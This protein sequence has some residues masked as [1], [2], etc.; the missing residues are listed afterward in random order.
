MV[1][2]PALELDGQNWKIYRA[3][4][5]EHAATYYCLDVLA[6]RPDD[7]T[8]D[9]HGSNALLWCTF[10]ETAPPTIYV[11]IR[12]KT[13]HE[14][15]NYLANCFRDYDP[16]QE[17][18][19]K[20]F[21]ARAN[22]VKHDPSAENPTS[23]Y[24]AI[25][26][27]R[28]NPPTKDLTRGT[29]DVDNRNVGR[30]QDPC[31]SPEAS[32]E[33]N[34]AECANGTSVLLTGEP[35]E[36]QNVPQDSLPLT[37]RPP[38]D[39]KPGECKQEAADGVVTAGCTKGAV[40]LAKPRKSDA[41]VDGKAAL[42]RVL[43]ER[44]HIVSEGDETERDGQSRLQQAEFYCKERCQ[45]NENANA[46][47]PST[48]ELPLEGEWTVCASGEARDPRGSANVPNATPECVHRPNESRETEDAEGVESEGCKGGTSGR[49][50]VDETVECCQQLCMADGDGGREV[51]PADTPNESETL[52]TVSIES[53]SPDGGGIPRVHLGSMSWRAGDANGPGNQA[54]GQ[55][56]GSRGWT[57]TLKVSNNA[58]TDGMS[59]GEGAETYLGAGGAKRV[60]NA[61]DGVGSR[62]DASTGPTDVPRVRTDAITTANASD[63]VSIPREESNMPNSPMET[64]KRT[65]DV[66]D[67]CGSHTDVSSAR[68]DA[69]C[70]GNDTETAT[71][72]TEIVRSHQ[73]KRKSQDSPNGH[74]IATP[75]LPGRW[76]KVS[77]GGGDVYVPLNTPIAV[78]TRQ[79][80]F[81]RVESGVEAIAPIA[82]SERA[83]DGDG[84]RNGGDGDGDDAES[85]GNVNSQR[86]EGARLST[87]SQRVCLHQKSQE[88]SPASSRPS[89]QPES[90][91]YGLVRRRRRCGRLKIER[92]NFNQVS[93]TPEDE[94]TH[95]E[96]VCATQLPRNGPNQAYGVYRPRRQRGR[97]KS[98]PTN[99]SRTRNS[100][101]AYLGRVTALRSNR[102]PKKQIRRFSKLTFEYRMLGEH[103]RDD[104]D[105]G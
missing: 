93:Q 24:A 91:P 62:T 49:E 76:R 89:I 54:N 95:L 66:P 42:G 38:I 34:S 78:P 18:C 51:E 56:D 88:N 4:I 13:A 100:G 61:T 40:Q 22:E 14:I 2:I 25:G 80:V 33:G 60:L 57:D 46:D 15:Y 83:G 104:G 20:K 68:M 50:S 105:Y 5:L 96:H 36:T 41:D 63:I 103:W 98:V 6:G 101:N 90:R 35:H 67:R 55:A 8:D 59:S 29:E 64:A 48:H 45:R 70:I 92:I 12:H 99:V 86:V 27:E 102:R 87:E 47:V 73:V 71:N 85:G 19:V 39:G 97:I 7:G 10:M 84:D 37:L 11:R 26:A 75:E 65:P 77:I 32:A 21:T 17:L 28:E 30:T 23:E 52:V 79:I 43:A 3:K 1:K 58:E 53:E 69:Y 94:T 31:T 74:D 72:E 44:V 82:E 9:W 16:I 81:G